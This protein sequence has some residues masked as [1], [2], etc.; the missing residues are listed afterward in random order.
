MDRRR[1]MMVRNQKLFIYRKGETSVKTGFNYAPTSNSHRFS[2]EGLIVSRTV[3]I[4]LPN[5]WQNFKKFCFEA[6]GKG[7]AVTEKPAAIGIFNYYT[8]QP[9]STEF[10]VYRVPENGESK[11]FEIPVAE[12]IEALKK[13]PSQHD[14]IES[15]GIMCFTPYAEVIAEN[16]WFE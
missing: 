13:K 5:K 9:A 16:I 14:S 10:G 15:I 12:I 3:Q 8:A 11:L 4:A 2:E 7:L 6:Y 1:M